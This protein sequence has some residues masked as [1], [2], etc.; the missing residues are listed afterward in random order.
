MRNDDTAE[1]SK[2][3][4]ALHRTA[5]GAGYWP[6]VANPGTDAPERYSRWIY[7]T[8]ALFRVNDPKAAN[9]W[10]RLSKHLEELCEELAGK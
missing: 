1:G 3:Q 8:K 2:H 5:R 9:P 7:V 6:T 10:D 4:A